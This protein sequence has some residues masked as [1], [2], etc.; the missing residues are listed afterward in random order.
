MYVGLVEI[1][2]CGCCNKPKKRNLFIKLR[3]KITLFKQHR[4][5]YSSITDKDIVSNIVSETTYLAH[6]VSTN[7]ATES[8]PTLLLNPSSAKPLISCNN[9]TNCPEI[10]LSLMNIT[11]HIVHRMMLGNIMI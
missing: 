11:E 8:N 10:D 4:V 6:M 3:L 7:L 5:S 9:T 2:L 1:K